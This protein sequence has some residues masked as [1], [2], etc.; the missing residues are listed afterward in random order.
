MGETG[1]KKSH[2]P[3]CTRNI[4][5]IVNIDTPMTYYPAI[6]DINTPHDRSLCPNTPQASVHRD[7]SRGCEVNP[8]VVEEW[9]SQESR[10]YKGRQTNPF[11]LK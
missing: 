9:R 11:K 5:H 8:E 3:R 1:R 6:S 4:I 2:I 7:C 10:G